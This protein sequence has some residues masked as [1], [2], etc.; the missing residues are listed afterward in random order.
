MA[1]QNSRRMMMQTMTLA[2]VSDPTA[3]LK[4]RMKGAIDPAPSSNPAMSSALKSTA[5]SMPKA[6]EPL[7]TR[8][9]SMDRGTSWVAFLTSSDIYVH[10]SSRRGE[11]P[12]RC[13]NT[14]D[15]GSQRTCTTESVPTKASAFPCNPTK[16]A[17]ACVLHLPSLWKVVKISLAELCVGDK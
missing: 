15:S 8:L 5:N 6:S 1:L 14:G 3:S 13:C 10:V 16:N 4:I 2:P 9:R 7:M 11:D 17:S 12:H